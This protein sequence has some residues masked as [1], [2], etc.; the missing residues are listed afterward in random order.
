MRIKAFYSMDS[1]LV[2]R[3]SFLWV[4]RRDAENVQASTNPTGIFQ[5]LWSRVIFSIFELTG[6]TME[7]FAVFVLA[8]FLK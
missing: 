7:L 6:T 2:S 4:E 5:F 3:T 1:T 8:V